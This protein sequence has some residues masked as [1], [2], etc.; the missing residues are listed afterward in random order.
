MRQMIS[1]KSLSLALKQLSVTFVLT[2][3]HAL[4]ISL[5]HWWKQ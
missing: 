1:P 2:G 4:L 3:Q 5:T